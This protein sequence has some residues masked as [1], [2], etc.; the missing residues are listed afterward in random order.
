MDQTCPICPDRT[1]SKG[2]Y[3]LLSFFLSNFTVLSDRQLINRSR[4]ACLLHWCI[5]TISLNWNEKDCQVPVAPVNVGSFGAGGLR[6]RRRSFLC[7]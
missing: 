1:F 7:L 2:P 4:R 6:G 5:L 3:S